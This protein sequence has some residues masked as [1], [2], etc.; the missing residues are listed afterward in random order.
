MVS[1]YLYLSQ[2]LVSRFT[3][4][5]HGTI[6]YMLKTAA[7]FADSLGSRGETLGTPAGILP[8][9]AESMFEALAESIAA[10]Y[11]T[12]EDFKILLFRG[13]STAPDG[14]FAA[15]MFEYLD[16]LAANKGKPDI[17]HAAQWIKM[18][19]KPP[20]GFSSLFRK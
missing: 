2:E 7:G 14:S 16:T 1:N 19:S 3:K 8:K 12:S 5:K 6:I 9:A 10:K 15:W 4:L 20:A 11:A 18:G 17:R 13:D